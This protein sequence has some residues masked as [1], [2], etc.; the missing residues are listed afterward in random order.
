MK[1]WLGLLGMIMIAG[2]V[3]GQEETAEEPMLDV[4]WIEGPAKGELSTI[5]TLEIPEG[6]FFAGAQDASKVMEYYGNI[7]SGAEIGYLESAASNGWWA[8]FQFDP[9]GFIK[10]DDKDQLDADK[11]IASLREDQVRANEQRRA[12]QVSE[13]EIDGWFK[14]PFYNDETQNLEWCT[15]LREQGVDE[16]FANHNIRILGRYGVTRI[17]LVADLDELDVAIPELAEILKSYDYLPGNTYAEYRKGD[18]VAKYGLTALVAGGAAAVAL[19]SGFF[20]YIWK[21]L[22]IGAIAIG[23]FF[24]KMF[25][26]GK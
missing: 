5:S 19:K 21:G 13:L 20:K 1:V 4:D 8:L 9:V 18:K 16:P 3:V 23:G 26:R 12:M 6:F 22:V 14:E 25:K 15:R 2:A 10:D 7:S 11:L 17:I 24:K